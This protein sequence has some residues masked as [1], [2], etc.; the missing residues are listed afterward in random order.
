MHTQVLMGLLFSFFKGCGTL[1]V[2]LP[3]RATGMP[4]ISH[5]KLPVVEP[6][7]EPTSIVDAFPSSTPVGIRTFIDFT[8]PFIPPDIIDRIRQTAAAWKNTDRNGAPMPPEAEILWRG[9]ISMLAAPKAFRALRQKF[10]ISQQEFADICNVKHSTVLRWETGQTSFPIEAISEL[11]NIIG[12]K[13]LIEPLT[14]NQ[15]AHLRSTLKFSRRH[16]AEAI[17]VA[18]MSII[19]WEKL[20]DQPLAQSA[21]AKVRDAAT[22]NNWTLAA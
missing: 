10:G 22:R 19:R 13:S 6:E 3:R 2:E 16:F 17:G 9:Y 11:Y 8:E 12:N 1:T 21:S 5:R 15:I 4:R 20:A 18:E 14:G 7:A